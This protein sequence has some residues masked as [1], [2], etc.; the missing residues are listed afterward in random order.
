E[1]PPR[2]LALLAADHEV[3]GWAGVSYVLADVGGVV[4]PVIFQH[5]NATVAPPTLSGHGLEAD[6][7]IVIGATTLAALHKHVGDTVEVTYGSKANHP[8]YVP[9]TRLKIVGT[10]TLPAVGFTSIVADHTSMGTGAILSYGVEPPAF[11]RAI[12]AGDPNE[13][14]PDLVFVRMQPGLTT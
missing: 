8:I 4:T 13:V 14:G 9:P 7:Q 6:D 10:A 5:P 11:R 2:T 1:V 12:A 3:A